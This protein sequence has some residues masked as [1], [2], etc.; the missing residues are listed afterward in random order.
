MLGV[1]NSSCDNG[2]KNPKHSRRTKNHHSFNIL[3]PS[4]HMQVLKFHLKGTT[5]LSFSYIENKVNY[6]NK[7]KQAGYGVSTN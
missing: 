4:N 5:I 2:P 1:R 6:R 7:A 3:K